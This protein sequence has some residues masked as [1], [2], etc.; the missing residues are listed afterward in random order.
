M[1]N[2]GYERPSQRIDTLQLGN[3][4][5]NFRQKCMIRTWECSNLKI[6]KRIGYA[7]MKF[8]K[9]LIWHFKFDN[10]LENNKT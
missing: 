3:M 2:I 4:D 8:F 6:K 9:L 5:M 7:D 1:W 10:T